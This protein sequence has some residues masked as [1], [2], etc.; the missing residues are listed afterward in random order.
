MP[1]LLR[2]LSLRRNLSLADE[3]HEQLERRE[4]QEQAAAELFIG[5]EGAPPL[6]AVPQPWLSAPAGCRRTHRLFGLLNPPRPAILL[7]A[8]LPA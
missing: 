6:A 1:S 4:E 5:Y 3:D 7:A 2:R 8:C